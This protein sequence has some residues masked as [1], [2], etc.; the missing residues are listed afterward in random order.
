MSNVKIGVIGVGSWGK[1]HLR[2][3]SELGCLAAFCD[4]NAER[5]KG[6]EKKYGVRGYCSV[7]EMLQK[8]V[9]NAVTICTPTITHGEVAK[10]TLNAGLHT[11]VEKPLTLS[12]TEGDELLEIAKKQG[13][14]LTAGYIERFNPAVSTLKAL[15]M[16]GRIGEPLLLEFHRE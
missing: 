13:V 1:N 5:V 11:F 12:S 3:L 9:L 2:V 6:Y 8:E 4:I 15:I 16:S 7:D 10:K 14:I